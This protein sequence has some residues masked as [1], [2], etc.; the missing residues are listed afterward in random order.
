VS[1]DANGQAVLAAAFSPTGTHILTAAF[2]GTP[3]FAPSLSAT[4]REAVK[5]RNTTTALTASA[6]P[7]PV[8]NVL[9]LTVTITPAVAAA[10]VPRGG[11]VFLRDGNT[12]IGVADVD[13]SGRAVFT[14]VPGKVM[15]HR[16]A[17]VLPR[18]THHLTASFT[19]YG[20]LAASASDTFDLTVV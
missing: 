11:Q 4:L 18:G 2:N 5:R 3:A 9:V 1:L 13:S 14:F 17:T 8:G 20:D 7:A 10:G 6:N 15:R 19:G 12:T 16:R